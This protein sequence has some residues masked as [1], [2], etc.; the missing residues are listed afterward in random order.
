MRKS[1]PIRF[2]ATLLT[3]A[4][5]PAR[6]TWTFLLLPKVASSKL[7]TRSQ[8][9]I[10]GTFNGKSFQAT[11]EPD[12]ENGHWLKVPARLRV[13]GGAAP[14]DKVRL[15]IT[16]ASRDTE[17]EVSA[18]LRR[19]LSAAPQAKA[20]W[21]DITPTARRDWVH[22]ITSAKQDATRMRRIATACD[23]LASGKRRVCCFDRSG[24]Y[25]KSLGAPEAAAAA[26]D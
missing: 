21:S 19:A 25:S 5:V 15:A 14:G 22:W 10:E 8:N 18:D 17:P 9:V 3:P 20:V 4:E 13:Q 12:G 11:L 24:R 26:T 2:I 16:P 7:P 6:E 23:M 1:A